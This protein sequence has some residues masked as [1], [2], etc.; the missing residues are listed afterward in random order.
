MSATKFTPEARGALIERVASG[1]SLADVAR[2]IGVREK[3]VKGWITRGRREDEGAYAAFAPRIGQARREADE[4]PEPMDA[5]E[6]ARA[7]SQAPRPDDYVNREPSPA[8][9]VVE[10]GWSWPPTSR[11]RRSGAPIV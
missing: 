1:V 11:S 4:P 10:G 9:G 5:D 3:T 2:A 6:L 7:P 8:R